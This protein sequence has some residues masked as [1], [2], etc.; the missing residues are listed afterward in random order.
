MAINIPIHIDQIVGGNEQP[1]TTLS[2]TNFD[3][4]LASDGS[5]S[6]WSAT[7]FANLG[8]GNYT[9]NGFSIPSSTTAQGAQ[10]QVKLNG[11]LKPALGTFNVY[12]DNGEPWS[13]AKSEWADAKALD[14]A[15]DQLTGN[16]T[17]SYNNG[18]GGNFDCFSM[19]GGNTTTVGLSAVA[20]IGYFARK[21]ASTGSVSALV[22][23]SLS[24]IPTL[25]GNNVF[26]GS[27][28]FNNSSFS[29]VATNIYGM[30]ATANLHK[31]NVSAC[32]VYTDAGYFGNGVDMFTVRFR[33]TG[34]GNNDL[35]AIG[36][37]AGELGYLDFKN[38]PVRNFSGNVTLTAYGALSALNTWTANNRFTGNLSAN[39]FFIGS[40]AGVSYNTS[41]DAISQVNSVFGV[42]TSITSTAISSI[43]AGLNSSGSLSNVAYLNKPNSFIAM[44][45][46]SSNHDI[47]ADC[48]ASQSTSITSNTQSATIV[49]QNYA[50]FDDGNS[51]VITW[52]NSLLTNR[53]AIFVT[54]QNGLSIPSGSIVSAYISNR[55]TGSCEITLTTN[56]HGTIF[57]NNFNV[58]LFAIPI[59]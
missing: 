28:T 43:T 27:N 46:F 34:G 56:D 30:A 20:P 18:T 16:D 15:G 53:S 29:F 38:T 25:S 58:G 1:V 24:G 45:N 7:G 12:T 54:I 31:V 35:F 8:N 51:I 9:L 50:A 13:R 39:K 22:G 41:S 48:G 19:T 57:V 52:N 26:N 17:L 21:Y 14:R 59:I 33:D 49:V 10:V 55:T 5:T 32:N 23:L 11:T 37:D 42:V 47:T 2:A 6:V 3:V 44:Q 40:T 36:F 4:V